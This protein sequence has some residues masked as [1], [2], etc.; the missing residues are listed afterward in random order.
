MPNPDVIWV[1]RG[2][3][4]QEGDAIAQGLVVVPAS[5][6]RRDEVPHTRVA[7]IGDEG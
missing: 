6:F 7:V 3:G 5:R 4:P 1:R 2:L